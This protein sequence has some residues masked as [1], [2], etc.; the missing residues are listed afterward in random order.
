[1]QGNG[2]PNI[3]HLSHPRCGSG[4]RGRSVL[5]KLRLEANLTQAKLESAAKLQ[6]KYVSILEPGERQPS[7]AT[8]FN[9]AGKLGFVAMR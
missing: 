1:M 6:R 8:V 3:N 2:A 5:C 4:V 9:L 7:L